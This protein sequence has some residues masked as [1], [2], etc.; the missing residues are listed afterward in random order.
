VT[1]VRHLVGTIPRCSVAKSPPRR[2]PKP[3]GPP[4][5]PV[6]AWPGLLELLILNAPVD[7][8]GKMIDLPDRED[9]GRPRACPP[10]P[11]WT[12]SGS[13]GG[14]AEDCLTSCDASRTTSESEEPPCFAIGGLPRSRTR[15]QPSR[16]DPIEGNSCTPCTA[17]GPARTSR[18]L[19]GQATGPDSPGSTG[20]STAAATPTK[21][22]TPTSTAASPATQK[23]PRTN[24]TP[25]LRTHRGAGRIAQRQAA[26]AISAAGLPRCTRRSPT[27]DGDVGRSVCGTRR[28]ALADAARHRQSIYADFGVRHLSMG[29]GT[30][31]DPSSIAAILRT[32]RAEDDP[33]LLL[34]ESNQAPVS[35]RTG[36]NCG[37][38]TSTSTTFPTRTTSRLCPTVSI[39]R[40]PYSVPWRHSGSSACSI[41]RPRRARPLWRAPPTCRSV[42]SAAS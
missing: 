32:L 18:R 7:A 35:T 33:F 19:S 14:A 3:S 41:E 40:S 12:G 6:S 2:R 8:S 31:L 30:G 10:R 42:R 24:P 25:V 4:R 20:R 36:T 11:A 38:R 22:S 39:P 21:P 26:A 23:P 5:R 15:G 34:V 28:V 17:D 27:V 37:S 9:P 13:G 16:G 1:P 29:T